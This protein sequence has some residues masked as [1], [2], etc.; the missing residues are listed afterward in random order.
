MSS[1]DLTDLD[2]REQT[3]MPVVYGRVQ[4]PGTGGAAFRVDRL[5]NR[6]AF[7]F[8]TPP[9]L[10]EPD[11]RLLQARLADAERL[12]GLFSVRPP[13]FEFG[14][15]GNAVTVASDT[16]SGRTVPIAGATPNYAIR[17]GQ[18]LSIVVDGQ[19]YFDR[20]MDQ[21]IV[22]SDGTASIRIANLI[23]VPLTEGDTVELA[24]P[25]IEGTVEMRNPAAWGADRMT[26]FAF[27]VTEDA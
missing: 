13:D 26:Q 23:R 10:V 5:G 7:D 22:A 12:G 20:A 24:A 3:L 25:K 8:L 4:R 19:R 14:S 15:P 21:V 18:P 16:A 27:T 9:M 6:T 17:R 1:I 11:G 2:F